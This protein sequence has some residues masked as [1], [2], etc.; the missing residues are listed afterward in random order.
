MSMQI[1]N[2]PT[3]SW[4]SPSLRSQTIEQISYTQFVSSS[5]YFNSYFTSS[6]HN[7]KFLISSPTTNTIGAAFKLICGYQ[8]DDTAQTRAVKTVRL[9]INSITASV[10]GTS[11]VY[12]GNYTASIPA[13]DS[14]LPENNKTYR[15]IFV[16]YHA[17]DASAATTNFQLRSKI[18]TAASA[19]RFT[20][21]QSLQSAAYYY[22]IESLS[23][24]I[25]TAT[26]HS[27]RLA[28][29]LANRFSNIGGILYVTYEYDYTSSR[30]LNSNIYSMGDANLYAPQSSEAFFRKRIY[31][32]ET[33][34]ITLVRSGVYIMNGGPGP[35]IL[36]I[37]TASSSFAR[38]TP[39][40]GT[41][42]TGASP[43]IVQVDGTG[44]H[45]PSIS[46]NSGYNDVK[47]YVHYPSINVSAGNAFHGVVL[48]LNYI[49]DNTQTP[50]SHTKTI[51]KLLVGNGSSGNGVQTYMY[52]SYLAS[53]SISD[54]RYFIS[55]LTNFHHFLMGASINTPIY[56]MMESVC[57]YTGSDYFYDAYQ[58]PLKIGQFGHTNDARFYYF[59]ASTDMTPYI[60]RYPEY[61][62]RA[63][64]PKID[65]FSTHLYGIR[66]VHAAANAV[67]VNSHLHYL[68]YHSITGSI[69]GNILNYSG[70]GAGI[71]L[72]V[73]EYESGEKLFSTQSKSGGV[74]DAY[75]YDTSTNIFILA[76][77]GSQRYIS[78]IQPA[79]SG[80]FIITIPTSS[81]AATSVEKSFTFIG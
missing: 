77:T 73:Y 30:I 66:N 13:L 52:S 10:L 27:I 14:F 3:A 4:T 42:T 62:N 19:S 12:L 18:D 67:S 21:S 15:D 25:D 63:N 59:P 34:S 49:S 33:G 64:N 31:I 58:N 2:Q 41:I 81:G 26:T 55:D 20:V 1:D 5:D 72:S 29:S 71:S 17:N 70:T 43:L 6:E 22:E 38:Y 56:G 37:G 8:Y 54:T 78:N 53:S 40:A 24:S 51:Q 60:R 46:L 47:L 48:Y 32:P 16:E 74:I 45:L 50:G 75:W 9:P 36:N 11:Q 44:S 65:I 76:E 7:L 28:S 68:T 35:Q 57:F 61:M 69:A 23:G 79:G 80:S 39:T